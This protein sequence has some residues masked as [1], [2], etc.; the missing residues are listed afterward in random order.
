MEQII[1]MYVCLFSGN[2]SVVDNDSFQAIK[3]LHSELDDDRDGN[4]NEAE[5]ADVRNCLFFWG[6]S[7]HIFLVQ[8]PFVPPRTTFAHFFR[9]KVVFVASLLPE[10]G[11]SGICGLCKIYFLTSQSKLFC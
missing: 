9:Q 5:S 7:F 1:L 3:Q 10:D 11:K 6:H 8:V 4:V 2:K